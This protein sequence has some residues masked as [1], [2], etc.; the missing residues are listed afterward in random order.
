MGHVVVP[1][2]VHAAKNDRRAPRALRRV[3]LTALCFGGCMAP[4]ATQAQDLEPRSYSNSPIGLNFLIGGYA[5]TEGSVLTD[6]SLPID[7]L[8]IETHS[9]ILGYATTFKAFGQ[10]AKFDL[11]LPAV[12]LSAEGDVAGVERERHVTGMGD[13]LFRIS[14]NFLGAPALTAAEFKEYH[15]DVIVGASL[16]VGAPLGRYDE[17]RLIN[18][19]SNRWSFR[20]EIGISKAIGPWTLELAPGAAIYTD[21]GDFGG[22][23]TREQEPLVSVQAGLSYTFAPG[24][25][26]AASGSWYKGGQ[27]TVDG[28]EKDDEQ[29][30]TRF[31]LTLALPVNRHHSIKIYAL[32]GLNADADRDLDAIGVAWQ[33]R[34]GGGF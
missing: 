4:P 31:G 16:R 17:D 23:K 6:P 3:I 26:L 18:I 25:W 29:E 28:V 27:T 21:N 12:S 22:G 5:H 19:G 32:T 34:W 13:P 20:P 15:Q 24:F 1:M 10:S 8:G 30:G 2:Q 14:V 11:I 33:Y 9:G 7:N